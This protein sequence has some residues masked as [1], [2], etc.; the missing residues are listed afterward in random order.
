M[1]PRQ[2]RKVSRDQRVRA[3]DVSGER[4]LLALV[5]E[6]LLG[7]IVEA[8]LD[9]LRAADGAEVP[10]ALR[11]PLQFDKKARATAA[12][13]RQVAKALDADAAL[14]SATAEFLA[15]QPAIGAAARSHDPAEPLVAVVVAAA[16][17]D[18][19][20]HVAALWATAPAGAEMALGAACALVHL[21]T[22]LGDLEAERESAQRQAESAVIATQRAEAA[23]STER[24]RSQR[25]Q[26][27]LRDERAARRGRDESAS[28]QEDAQR[29]RAEA[30]EALAAE[31]RARADGAE[32]RAREASAKAQ[33]A[34]D[35]VKSVRSELAAANA[36]YAAVVPADDVRRIAIRAQD[37]GRDLARLAASGATDRV[38][39]P[40]TARAPR[41]RPRVKVRGGLTSD[42][43]QG[44]AG[45]LGA[46]GLLLVV[47]GYNAAFVGW[48]DATAADKREHLGRGLVDLHRRFGCDVLCVFD[49][50]GTDAA[51]LRLDGVRVVFS[52][53]GE[54]ADAVVVRSVQE[55]ATDRPAIVVSSDRWVHDHSE[56][57]GAIAVPSQTL[58]AIVRSRTT[59]GHS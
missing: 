57:A 6:T 35:D 50:D 39:E 2:R 5:P 41:R 27:D 44:L 7:P 33:Q 58:I 59:P 49:G 1:C 21:E 37:I 17:G 8:T 46:A 47:D 32:A 53:A 30:A 29:R 45:M 19:E 54:E 43:P 42:S 20:L 10:V 4:F 11:G 51:P 9:R 13:R 12:V 55:L 23:L 48:P 34:R 25:F 28:A 3:S 56:A 38:E 40:F 26:N 18:I 36:R 24:E 31:E 14:A 15:A 16:R 52:A 22:A